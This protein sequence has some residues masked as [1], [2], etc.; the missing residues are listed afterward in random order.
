MN[1]SGT[2]FSTSK[3]GSGNRGFSTWN[4]EAY[5]WTELAYQDLGIDKL[6]REVVEIRRQTERRWCVDF[7]AWSA[8]N[9]PGLNAAWKDLNPDVDA[10]L[11]GYARYAETLRKPGDAGTN[12]AVS[13]S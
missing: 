10:L 9:Q 13:G 1:C 4:A 3:G 11:A 2:A 12:K 5:L 8:R 7:I 6:R